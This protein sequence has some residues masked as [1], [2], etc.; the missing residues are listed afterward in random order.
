MKP[1]EVGKSIRDLRD[2]VIVRVYRD[3][4]PLGFW[5]DE[6][7]IL[8]AGDLIVEITHGLVGRE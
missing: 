6:A 1:E 8:K 4:Q 3:G 5:E 7:Q 2:S